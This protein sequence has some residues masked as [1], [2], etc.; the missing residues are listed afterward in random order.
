[1]SQLLRGYSAATVGPTAWDTSKIDDLL[2]YLQSDLIVVR[3]AALGNLIAYYEIP[4]EIA[5]GVQGPPPLADVGTKGPRYEQFVK[6]WE[7]RGEEIKKW[8][9]TKQVIKDKK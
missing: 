7:N 4:A 1:M 8:M 2:K 5:G 6:A 3:E 9:T